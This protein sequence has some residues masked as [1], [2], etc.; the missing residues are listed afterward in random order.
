MAPKTIVVPLDG[1]SFAER[2]LPVAKVLARRLDAGLVLMTTKS[3]DWDTDGKVY[4]DALAQ[5]VDG[6]TTEV[7]CVDTH[8]A[9]RAIAEVADDGDGD[10]IVCMASHGRGVVGWAALGSVAEEVIQ[11]TAR[12]IVLVG[13]HCSP[14]WGD[15]LEQ[16]VV[17]VDGADADDPV[18][19]VASD[20]AHALALHVTIAHVIHPLDV[21]GATHRNVAV[22]AIAQHLRAGGVGTS[23]VLLRSSFTAGAIADYARDLPGSIITMG[24]HARTGLKRVALGSV[25][26]AT[27]GIATCPVLLTPVS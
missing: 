26:L 12:P 23:R 15:P 24:T 21:E 2:A 18:I 25:A 20:W 22:E 3:G 1:S 7:V 5:H 10:R 17:C 16:L 6:L 11:A 9:S 8:P 4:L 27:V 14:N 19:P 13:R